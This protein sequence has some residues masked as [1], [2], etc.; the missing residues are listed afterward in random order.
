MRRRL[1]LAAALVDQPPVLFLDEPTTGLDPHGR[2]NLWEV[3]EELAADGTTVLLTTQYLEEADRLAD[4][5]I[6]INDGRIIAEGTPTELKAQLGSTVIEVGLGDDYSAARPH[7][8]SRRSGCAPPRD[9]G[10]TAQLEVADGARTL[11]Q[12]LPARSERPRDPRA[13]RPR[14][15]PR[16]RVP[17]AHRRPPRS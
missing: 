12:A 1:D 4:D 2:S 13:Q 11:V 10:R 9:S 6:L 17:V 7:R 14:A 3:I 15:Q 5:I 8:S 16:R